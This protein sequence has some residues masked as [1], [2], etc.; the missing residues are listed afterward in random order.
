MNIIR[1]RW[2]KKKTRGTSIDIDS[3]AQ[4]KVLSDDITDI[5]NRHLLI[6][7]SLE[8]LNE[9][10][11]KVI[12]LRI[13]EGYS[14]SETAGLMGIKAG[15]VRVLQYRALKNLVIIMNEEE[16]HHE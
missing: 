9:D 3:I 5:A 13:I 4:T 14:V 12:E 16:N 1:D 15:N 8:K 6:R 10:Q 2:R 11:R 7:R